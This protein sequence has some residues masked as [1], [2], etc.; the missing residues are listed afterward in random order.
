MDSILRPQAARK[1]IESGLQSAT[2]SKKFIQSSSSIKPQANHPASS[3]PKSLAGRSVGHGS[4]LAVPVAPTWSQFQTPDLSRISLNWKEIHDMDRCM[5]LLQKGAPV[6]SDTLPQDWTSD[7]FEKYPLDEGIYGLVEL[8]SRDK[9]ELLKNRYE[10]V[11]R[12]LQNFFNSEPEPTNKNCWTLSKTEGFNVYRLKSGS[13]YWKHQKDSIVEGT[14]SSISANVMGSTPEMTKHMVGN[15]NQ[16]ATDSISEGQAKLETKMPAHICNVTNEGN[17]PNKPCLKLSPVMDVDTERT[18]N[19]DREDDSERGAITETEDT[20]I[21]S[22]RGD[23]SVFSITSDAAL[24]ELLLPAEQSMIEDFNREVAADLV[25]RAPRCSEPART[26]VMHPDQTLSS[27]TSV[28][29]EAKAIG[30]KTSSTH[31]L[32]EAAQINMENS[33]SG[34]IIGP[35][36]KSDKPQTPETQPKARKRKS[37]A[38][39]TVLVHED[40]PGRTPLIK[41]MVRMNPVSPGTDIPKEN[42]EDDGLVEDSSQVEIGIPQTRRRRTNETIGTPSIRRV[43]HLGSATTVAPPYRSLF[44][45]PGSSR[46]ARW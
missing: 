18:N 10:T 9:V 2:S 23:H 36:G 29:L 27:L 22:M 5:F 11:R 40:L 41:K 39:F 4:G 44:Q 19:L 31:R 20:L 32:A 3:P 24:E 37:G 38:G 43:H 42:L 12:G 21:K 33:T 25:S 46:M 28:G 17:R 16:E 35:R 8:S 26:A 1:R 14:T 15:R 7:V 30:L 6:D 13:R 45:S 34:D